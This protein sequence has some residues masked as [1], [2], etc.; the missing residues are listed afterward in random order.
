[1]AVRDRLAVRQIDAGAVHEA[2]PREGAV[3]NFAALE[4]L[5]ERRGHDRKARK[6]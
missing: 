4:F 6:L 5:D 1:M 3:L 2:M